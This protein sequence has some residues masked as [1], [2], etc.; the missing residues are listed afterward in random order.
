LRIIE[1]VVDIN[2]KRKKAMATRVVAA[3][4]GSVKGKTVAVLGLTFK[5]NTDDMRDS[6]SL[7]I[8]P[9]LQ[10]AGAKVVAYDP[11]GMHEAKAMLPGVELA[12]DA[13]SAMDGA[14]CALIITEWNEFRALQ[15]DRVKKLLKKPVIVDLRNCYAP[16]DMK[17]AGFEYT[18]I[19]RPATATGAEAG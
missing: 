2:D 19:G 11:E 17:A 3:C 15:L 16:A 8:L 6:P 18:S 10:E 1:T 7:D 9:A 5:P 14:D 4:G 13:Y 12:K